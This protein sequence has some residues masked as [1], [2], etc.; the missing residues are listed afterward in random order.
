MQLNT[1]KASLGGSLIATSMLALA[2]SLCPPAVAQTQDS[3]GASLPAMSPEPSAQE[4]VPQ[5]RFRRSRH[6]RKH[7]HHMGASW[8]QI[9]S[10]PSL[11]KEQ[12]KQIDQIIQSYKTEL[13]PL[14]QEVRALRQKLSSKDTTGNA[15][16][17][18][19]AKLT[20]LKKELKTKNKLADSKVKS[21][22]TKKQMD[23]LEKM[24]ELPSATPTTKANQES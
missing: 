12:S 17:E 10:L 5:N 20:D 3:S 8:R 22:L 6:E 7:G 19:Q 1:L 14:K 2:L 23:E 9:Q 4:S 11:T 21:V 16:Q 15:A 18:V 13:K 24:P